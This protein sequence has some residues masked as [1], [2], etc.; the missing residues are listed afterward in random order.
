M[1][2][3]AWTLLALLFTSVAFAGGPGKH[4]GSREAEVLAAVRAE[5]PEQYQ[6]LV[7]LK[8][9]DPERYR[10]A[11]RRAGAIVELRASDPTAKGREEEMK[12]LRQQIRDLAKDADTLD[13]KALAA[14]RA[15]IEPLASRMFDL[16]VAERRAMLDLGDDRLAAKRDKVDEK[17]GEKDKIV[18][19]K[20]DALLSGEGKGDREGKGERKGKRK[21]EGL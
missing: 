6:K 7:A 12:S 10:H 1:P 13:A 15:Q 19:E 5:S 9:A 16:K 8:D 3:S 11:L 4:D 14:R 2:R 21:S 20:I 17:A 18:D